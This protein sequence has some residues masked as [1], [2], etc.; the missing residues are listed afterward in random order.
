MEFPI[1][2]GGISDVSGVAIIVS[3]CG[4]STSDC[5][6]VRCTSDLGSF[7]WDPWFVYISIKN[8]VSEIVINGNS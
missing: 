3:S 7:F 8:Y 1:V 4:Y 2:L 6:I 5:P